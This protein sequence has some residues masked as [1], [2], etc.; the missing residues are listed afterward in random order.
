M[1]RQ[2][3][4]SECIVVPNFA[5][6]LWSTHLA[7]GILSATADNEF[8]NASLRIGFSI[9]IFRS[10]S[11][12]VVIV[13]VDDYICVRGIQRIPQRFHL[14]V[15]AVLS[16]RTEQRLVKICQRAGHVVLRQILPEPLPL[17]GR[18]ITASNLTALAV[19]NNDVPR[20]QIVTVIALLRV[21]S[22]GAEIARIC[23]GSIAV[24]LMVSGRGAR[25]ILEAAPRWSI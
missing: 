15:V 24:V 12:V 14:R 8:P 10:K 4:H 7:M 25:A 22:G 2:L 19:Q 18:R 1:Q 3:K 9:G 21:A 11:L 5:V 20:T 6:G 16:A 17:R 23:R 13:S